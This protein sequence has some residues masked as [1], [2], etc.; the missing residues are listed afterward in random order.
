METHPYW[1]KQ[2]SEPLYKDLLWDKPE[3]KR[4]AGKLLIVGG[5]AHSFTAP[6]N[7]YQAAEEAGIGTAKVLLPQALQKVVGRIIE[8][9]EFAP[10]NKSGSFAKNALEEW[11]SLSTW[12]DGVLLA[13]DFGRNSETAIV[14]EQFMNLTD[15][16]VAITQ[17]ALD[18]FVAEPHKLLS[19][20]NAICIASFAQLQKIATHAQFTTAFT[21][22][23]TVNQ[24]V[25]ALHLFTSFHPASIVT[26]HG[27]M[28]YVATDG[29]VS[30]TK[31]SKDMPVWRVST[32][33]IAA[34]WTLQHPTKTFAALTTAIFEL[35]K[36]SSSS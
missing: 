3:N 12:A 32:A 8:N 4:Q 24:M 6:A 36:N 23:M 13:G 31:A 11:L 5:N 35:N 16:P 27:G 34:V 17:D 7:A 25:E 22:T 15:Q 2:G 29:E 28:Y 21:Y 10:S 18:Y 26:L 19:K 33:A 9:G 1:Q 14:L 20:K 30:T